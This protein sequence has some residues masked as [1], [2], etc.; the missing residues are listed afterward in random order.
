MVLISPESFQSH[1]TIILETL[2]VSRLLKGNDNNPFFIIYRE[3]QKVIRFSKR[4]RGLPGCPSIL[5]IKKLNG[6]KINNSSWILKR[7]EGKGQAWSPT[8]ERQTSK[9]KKSPLIAETHQQK[10]LQDPVPGQKDLHLDDNSGFPGGS[11]VENPPPYTRDAGLI[12][13]SER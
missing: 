2:N 11:V 6:L 12:P 8:L 10:L 13:G 3:Q 9:C 5:T 7:G 1:Y 4:T